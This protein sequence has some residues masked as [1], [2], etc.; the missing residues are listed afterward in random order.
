MMVISI[1]SPCFEDC[2]RASIRSTEIESVREFSTARIQVEVMLLRERKED[3][4]NS[5]DRVLEQ[6]TWGLEPRYIIRVSPI[7]GSSSGKLPK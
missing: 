3:L 5:S 7:T 1:S 2:G 6:R 4:D